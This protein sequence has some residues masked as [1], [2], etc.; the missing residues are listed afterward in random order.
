MEKFFLTVQ[1]QLIKA[2]IMEMEKLP[3][4]KC[5]TY[6]CFRKCSLLDAKITH[7][8]YGYKQDIYHLEREKG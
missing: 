8:Q 6:N 1:F 3:C 7:W 2:E 4:G 5:N